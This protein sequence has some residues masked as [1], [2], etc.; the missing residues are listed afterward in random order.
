[1]LAG[2]CWSRGMDSTET[3]VLLMVALGVIFLFMLLLAV[4][5]AG[6]CLQ[7]IERRLAERE[8]PPV[9]EE[10]L[11]EAAK[12]PNDSAFREF[13]SEDPE[14]RKLPKREQFDA[15]RLWRK[16]KGLNWSAP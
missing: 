12:L 16:E 5:R 1:M 6:G 13:L 9:A 11:P 2:G 3:M 10:H 7:R 15:Y 4:V 8:V 14:R